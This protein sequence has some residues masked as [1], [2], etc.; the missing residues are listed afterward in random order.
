MLCD[1]CDQE[2]TYIYIDNGRQH[3]LCATCFRPILDA[4]ALYGVQCYQ[5]KKLESKVIL[6]DPVLDKTMVVILCSEECKKSATST[7]YIYPS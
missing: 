2:T 7:V 4:V 5:C 6:L 1:E 3:Y